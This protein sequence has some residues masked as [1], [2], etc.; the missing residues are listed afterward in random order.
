M[1]AVATAALGFIGSS[2]AKMLADRVLFFLA[3]KALLL[4]LFL[5]VMPIVLNNIIG[6]LMGEALAYFQSKPVDGSWGG[7]QQFTGLF[8]WLVDCFQ[9]PAAFSVFV[10][11][12]QLRVLLR[13]IP[14]SPVK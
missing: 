9:I 5:V 6:S 14:F 10:S 1:I 11:A 7:I 12:L 8:G 4:G 13:M 2:V 3:L